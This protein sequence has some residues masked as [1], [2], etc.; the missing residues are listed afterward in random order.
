ARQA[1]AL[2]CVLFAP[3][4]TQ[5]L[6]PAGATANFA[7]RA[8]M[9]RLAIEGEA[10]FELS[11]VDA[12]RPGGRPNYTIDSL[13]RLGAELP[14]GSE[15]FCLM[16]ADSFALLR[17]WRRA[18]EIPFRAAL[19]VAS[20]PGERLEELERALPEGVWLEG[21]ESAERRV[22]GVALRSLTLR[23]EAGGRA[24]FHLLPGLDIPTSATEIRRRVRAA[25]NAEE[26]VARPVIEYIRRHCLYG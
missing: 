24:A 16:G 10:G 19:I 1:L 7:A 18:A 6:K 9:A 3:V 23:N 15:L 21:G 25:E 5:P 20:R 8:E 2:D 11:L 14:P 13:E 12:P 26:L 22:N 17:K 4:G